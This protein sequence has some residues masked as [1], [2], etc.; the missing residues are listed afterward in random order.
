MIKNQW[1]NLLEKLKTAKET[2]LPTGS[3]YS[4]SSPNSNSSTNNSANGSTSKL[5]SPFN[6][7]SIKPGGYG[8]TNK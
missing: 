3:H 8:T 6:G 4:S 2:V 7:S 5:A 1:N